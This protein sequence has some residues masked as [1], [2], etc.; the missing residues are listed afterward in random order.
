MR[1][2]RAGLNANSSGFGLYAHPKYG[3]LAEKSDP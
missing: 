3:L 1:S 2:K